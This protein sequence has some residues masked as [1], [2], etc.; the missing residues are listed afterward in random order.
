MFAIEFY[1]IF[2]LICEFCMLTHELCVLKISFGMLI[3]EFST[4]NY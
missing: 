2:M 3:R 1:V 4:Y